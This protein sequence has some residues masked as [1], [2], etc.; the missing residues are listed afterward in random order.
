MSDLVFAKAKQTDA[1][2]TVLDRI[3]VTMRQHPKLS[4]SYGDSSTIISTG[5]RMLHIVGDSPELSHG[6][7]SESTRPLPAVFSPH[8]SIPEAHSV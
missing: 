1:P 8:S 2:S 4:T 7:V 5:E 3:E 6:L